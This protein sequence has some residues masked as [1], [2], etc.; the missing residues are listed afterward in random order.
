MVEARLGAHRFND[1]E[2][3]QVRAFTTRWVQH[4]AWNSATLQND[5]AIIDLE[6]EVPLNGMI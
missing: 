1:R 2:D 4:A 5:I 3:S 6:Q